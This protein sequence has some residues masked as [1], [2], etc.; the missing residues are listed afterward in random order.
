MPRIAGSV[1][2]LLNLLPHWQQT[3][4]CLLLVWGAA[5]TVIFLVMTPSFSSVSG[6]VLRPLRV[7]CR[8]E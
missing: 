2:M 5:I 4:M 6:L 8:M 1:Q 3:V 7:E